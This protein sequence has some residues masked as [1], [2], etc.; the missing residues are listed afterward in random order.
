MKCKCCNNKEAD[1]KNTHYLTDAIIRK[2]LNENGTNYREKGFMF[3]LSNKSPFVEFSFQRETKTESI[4]DALGRQPTDEEINEAKKNAFSVDYF[5]CSDCEKLFTNIENEFIDKILPQLRGMDFQEA[6][7]R[8]IEFKEIILIRKFFLLQFW[9][10][11]VCDP[12]FDLPDTFRDK[13]FKGIFNDDPIIKEIP[14]RVTYLNTVG[15]DYEYT[16][17]LVGTLQDKSNFVIFFNDFVLQAF[18]SEGDINFIDLFGL[19]EKSSFTKT[20]NINEGQ[21]NIDI[22]FNEERIDF[23]SRLYQKDFVK[24]T[25]DLYQHIFIKHFYS[26]F[27]HPPH[28]RIIAS[29]IQ[30]IIYGKD[31]TEEKR[32]SVER[33]MNYANNYFMR[34]INYR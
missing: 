29:F 22:L 10:T 2:C 4:I 3:G 18:E 26:T 7:K 21:F 15:D 20:F 9:R 23:A 25:L 34:L 24:N 5:F 13:L 19:N 31:T 11:S 12:S 1:K 17:N 28:P 33:F 14:L 27:G 32:Y 30:G 8:T 6:N 16:K